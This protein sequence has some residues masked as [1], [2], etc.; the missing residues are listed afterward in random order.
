[1][2]VSLVHSVYN[3]SLHVEQLCTMFSGLFSC[4]AVLCLMSGLLNKTDD[5]NDD[6]EDDDVVI[7]WLIE[8]AIRR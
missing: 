2:P 4:S 5:V 8:R 1:M 3:K 7:L 6:Y